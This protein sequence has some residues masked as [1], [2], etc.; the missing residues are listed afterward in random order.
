V[1]Y[2]VSGFLAKNTDLLERDLSAVMFQAGHPI[3][4]TL[5]PEGAFSGPA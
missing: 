5:F 3:L 1:T 4:K 2:S